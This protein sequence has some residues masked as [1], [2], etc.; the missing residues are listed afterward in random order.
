MSSQVSD[1]LVM[2]DDGGA[3]SGIQNPLAATRL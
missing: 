3:D 1:L 2:K